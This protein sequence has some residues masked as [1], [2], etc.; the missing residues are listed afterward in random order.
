MG[1]IKNNITPYLRECAVDLLHFR[2][3]NKY[4][5]NYL[6]IDEYRIMSISTIINAPWLY[7]IS[8]LANYKSII[9][10]VNTGHCSKYKELKNLHKSDNHDKICFVFYCCQPKYQSLQKYML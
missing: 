6:F 10:M 3:V 5:F 7:G 9:D 8:K 2:V 4:N 1:I